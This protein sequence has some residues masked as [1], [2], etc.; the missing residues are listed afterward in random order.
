[1]HHT[2]HDMRR[3]D[4]DLTL[5]P[6]DLARFV[7]CPHATSLDWL[8]LNGR[9][10]LLAK[11]GDDLLPD[12]L[13]RRGDEHE[14][15]ILQRMR[16][17]GKQIVEIDCGDFSTA[18]LRRSA[19]ATLDA[20]RAGPDVIY[21]AAFLG[22]RHSGYAD[23]LVRVEKPSSLGDFS[24][25]AMDA[26]LA[27]TVRPHALLQLC[28]YT[29]HLEEIQGV[30]PD[31]LH[32]ILGDK[33]TASF[34]GRDFMALFAHLRQAL[35]LHLVNGTNHTSPY[36]VE[37][38][39]LCRYRMH[40]W[41]DLK[42]RDHLS[43]VAG[44]RRDQVDRLTR[45]GITTLTELAEL[46]P[47][48]SLPDLATSTLEPL[49]H[50]ASLQLHHKR[51]GTHRYDI[52]PFE[53]A[54]GF[55][56]LPEPSPGD[57]F[58][59]LEADPFVEDGLTYL[60]GLAWTENGETTYRP[61]WAHDD[62]AERDALAAV[63]DFF[64]ERR[65][66][67]PE[68]HIYHYGIADEVGIRK[69]STR[70]GIRENEIDDLLRGDVFADLQRV[71]RQSIRISQPSYS[72]KKLETFYFDREE[73]GVADAGGA[74]LAYEQWLDSGNR[75]LLVA[76]ENYNREDCMSALQL[77]S[78]LLRVRDEAAQQ[79]GRTPPWRTPPDQP[80]RKPESIDAELEADDLAT[81][82]IADLPGNPD[83]ATDDQR[84][85]HLLAHLLHYHRRDARPAWWQ[86][87]DRLEQ[88]PEE[89]LDDREAIACL[90]LEESRPPFREKKSL[91]YTYTFPPQ[92]YKLDAGD[93]VIDP[94]TKSNAGSIVSIDD[95]NGLLMLKRGATLQATPH[96][97][98]IIPG[99]P[100]STT[101]LRS[102]LRRFATD[103]RDHGLERTRYRAAAS[104]LMRA[105]PD[106]RGHERGA[107]LHGDHVDIDDIVQHVVNLERSHLFIQGPP[108]A[109]KTYSGGYLIAELLLRGKRIGIASNSHKAIHN[110]LHTVEDFAIGNDLR[111]LGLCKPAP[112]D[113]FVSKLD[114]PMFENCKDIDRWN[115]P[116][117]QIV[118]GTA[119]AFA[120]ESLEG[121]LDHLFI[122][123]AGQVS[124]ANALV[125]AMAAKNVVLLGD[126]LQLAQVSQATHPLRSGA[127][128]LE[129]IL[130]DD[131]T[132]PRNRGVF[133]EESWRMH[134]DVCR[135]V[136]EVVYEDRLT[137]FED[138]A[139]QDVSFGRPA[140]RSATGLRWVPIEHEANASES[141][142]EAAWIAES[143][144]ELLATGVITDRHGETRT[145][146]PADVM[147]VTPY[148]AQV[149]RITNALRGV[150]VHD[151]EVGTVDK[152]QGREAYVV[153]F[154][155]ATSSGADLPRNIDF[156]FS[157]NRLNVAISRAR[158]LA[159]LVASPHLLDV[160]CKTPE[161]MMLV[162]ALCRFVEMAERQR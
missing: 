123:E 152:F 129:H 19:E 121:T 51:T 84:N 98:A 74:I 41:V 58:L 161:Q 42:R 12:V 71:V 24:Y 7:R 36:P 100:I 125:I 142:E 93:A 150:G 26:K 18:A 94:A 48:S 133:L 96:P 65:K 120:D 159:V 140:R 28:A 40:C 114:E 112:D 88:S 8:R 82:L 95:N 81:A 23:F 135:F 155:M 141:P 85:R 97:A 50:Q 137:S 46:E 29:A 116:E 21:Q 38:C 20:M 128:V 126:P 49:R 139:L 63:I 119:W 3:L 111:F 68:M 52:L 44:I 157:R 54:R 148:N 145:I 59:D 79:C 110:L 102:A 1:M 101:L 78:W 108:G 55:E 16:E 106:I 2:L 91:V 34:R 132:I 72:L 105:L 6:T 27:R 70:H 83:E 5:S 77:R 117:V 30:L 66:Q 80:E 87:F 90:T 147:V 25:E 22:P 9:L 160:P 39:S 43:I 14:A 56:R 33:Q 37:Y 13:A 149:R 143:I 10:E 122:D 64:V 75:D 162:N 146:R 103:V 89:L 17:E 158:C 156:L 76:I 61:F 35:D 62:V 4:S 86:Y 107:G 73:E 154:S 131:A 32:V 47:G 151:V 127:S 45:G 15:A 124:L 113:P 136:S 115:D 69:L 11:P 99:K 153:Y 109:G 92:P 118:A 67:Y 104:I 134:P 60:F 57:V 31:R 144:V 130:G 138:C 53:D